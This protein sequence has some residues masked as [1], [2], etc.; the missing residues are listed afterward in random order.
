MVMRLLMEQMIKM[1]PH[2]G[3]GMPQAYIVFKIFSLGM[4]Y[5]TYIL[6]IGFKI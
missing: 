3:R 6:N 4:M 5:L 2:E 1:G